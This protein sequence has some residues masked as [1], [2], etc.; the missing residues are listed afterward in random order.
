MALSVG[1]K[2]PYKFM[3]QKNNEEVAYFTAS[4]VVLYNYTQKK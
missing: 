2:H 1:V 3:R 4:M